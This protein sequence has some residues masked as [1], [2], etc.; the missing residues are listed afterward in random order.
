MFGDHGSALSSPAAHLSSVEAD[1][2]LW[3]AAANC[4]NLVSGSSDFGSSSVDER[5]IVLL[6]LGN[7]NLNYAEEKLNI[8]IRGD[9]V[10]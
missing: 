1:D 10:F 4:F 7:V 6:L 2:R 9:A 8:L 5:G 3:R